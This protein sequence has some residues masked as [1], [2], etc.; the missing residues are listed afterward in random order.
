MAIL[1]ISVALLYSIAVIAI[2]VYG[3]SLATQSDMFN[4]FGRRAGFFRA[5][6]GYLSLLGGGELILLTQL[7]FDHGFDFLWLP[8]GWSFGFL[9]LAICSERLRLIARERNINTLSGY[10]TDQFGAAAGV[11]ISLIFVVSLGSLLT[12]QFIVGSDLLNAI[13][14]M[15][16][17]ITVALMVFVILS[18]L[19]PS[20]FVAVLSTDVLRSIM[21]TIA[22]C[23]ITISAVIH[24]ASS[25]AGFEHYTPL[26][27]FERSMFL[28]LGMFGVICAADVW[29][30]VFASRDKSTNQRA[31]ISAALIFPVL[32]LLVAMLGI[33]TKSVISTLGSEDSALVAAANY[34]LPAAL[35][36]LVALLITGSVMATADTEIWVISSLIVSL[37]LAS[38]ATLHESGLSSFQ[39]R[40]KSYTRWV[41]PIVAISASLLAILSQS[42]VALYEGLLVLLTAIAPVMCVVPFAKLPQS[43]VASGLWGAVIS[44]GA[45]SVLRGFS[46]PLEQSFYPAFGS[47]LCMIISFTV[48][49]FR[50]LVS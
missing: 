11:A 16:R 24:T 34:A 4:I 31:L 26:G 27:T 39:D 30:T 13:T 38:G 42:A 8:A 6:A 15:P 33:T 29:Q 3:R 47:C 14:G 9:F 23:I 17:T 20:G 46:I 44:F 25:N 36:P 49:K 40:V 19:L 12:I 32:A 5:V 43:V 28:I 35:A 10:F 45:L 18:Y 41:M 21:M 50:A 1:S 22:L 37:R 2:G 7:G 48:S